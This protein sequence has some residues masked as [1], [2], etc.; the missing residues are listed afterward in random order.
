VSTVKTVGGVTVHDVASHAGVSIATVSR[1]LSGNRPMSEELRSRVMSSVAAL[2]YQVNL[3]GR[4]LRQKR[5]ST[6]GLVIPDLENPFFSSLAQNISRSFQASEIEVMI[7]SADN[8]IHNELRAVQSFLGRQVDGLVLVPS[9]EKESLA[10][11]ELAARYAPTI[12]FDRFV[13]DTTIPFVGGDNRYGMQLVS[14]HIS[15]HV[16]PD[17]GTLFFIGGGESSSS[18]RE[19]SAAFTALHPQAYHREGSFSFE[20][21]QEAAKSIIAQG[22]TRGTIVCAADVIAL[23]VSSW[24]LSQGFGIPQDFRLIGFDDVGVSFLAHPT[25]TTV[26]QPLSQMTEAIGAML[27]EAK[28]GVVA[29]EKTLFQPELVVRESSPAR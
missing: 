18:G 25:L 27:Q 28:L 3:V 15:Q 4:A 29:P 26:R 6:L 1:A 2:G 13:P 19:R 22:H 14:E 21:G 5:T 12:Q 10:A 7:S 16:P 11:V 24:L 23:G 8:D 17:Q 20:W 9:D